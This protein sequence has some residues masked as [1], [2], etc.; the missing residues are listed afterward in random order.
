MAMSK[1]VRESVGRAFLG[2]VFLSSTAAAVPQPSF[3]VRDANGDVFVSSKLVLHK[4]TVFFFLATDCPNANSYAPE[5]NRIFHDYRS[6]GIAFYSVY[7]DPS[8]TADEVRKHDHDYALTF[9]S[10]LDPQQVVARVAGA[11]GT[12]EV[13]VISS[14]GKQLYRGRIDDRFANFGKTRLHVDKHDL[15]VALDEI[16]S[17]QPV[18]HPYMPSLGCAI[19]GVN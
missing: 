10:L 12:P 15:R 4:A 1:L 6:R 11:R 16:L 14:Q 8:E 18:E 19:P 17:G 5:M 7:S 13:V 2:V 9:P 3:S